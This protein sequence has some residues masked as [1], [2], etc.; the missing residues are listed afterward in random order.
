MSN[1]TEV[2]YQ[3]LMEI[4]QKMGRK[5]TEVS[6]VYRKGIADRFGILLQRS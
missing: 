2:E 5:I 1:G 6:K 3:S 4:A